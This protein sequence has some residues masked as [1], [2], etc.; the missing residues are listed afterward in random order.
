MNTTIDLV[1][2]ARARPNEM[3]DSRSQIAQLSKPNDRVLEAY[4]DNLEGIT[5][6]RNRMSSV[7]LLFGHQAPSWKIQSIC[8]HSRNLSKT[9]PLS[10]PP[11]PL[12]FPETRRPSRSH[13]HLQQRTCC[14]YS[15]RS[16]SHARRYP[17]HWHDRQSISDT[18]PRN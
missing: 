7:S 14:A 5:F 18:E 4:G 16:G 6:C 15:V 9:L 13:H 2:C 1:Q 3:L 11:S 17:A 12:A 10:L 8:S